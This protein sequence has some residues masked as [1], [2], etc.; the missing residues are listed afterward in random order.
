M[1]FISNKEAVFYE[2]AYWLL[3]GGFGGCCNIVQW[4]ILF[5]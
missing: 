3:R 5:T 1:A 2:P 4:G